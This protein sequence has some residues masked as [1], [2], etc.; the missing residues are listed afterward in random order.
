MSKLAYIPEATVGRAAGVPYV[1][2]PPSDRVRA[3]APAVVGWHLGDPP[4]TETALAAALPLREL[5]AWRIYL[6]LPL[7]GSRL[8]AG[9]WDE[10]MQAASEDAVLKLQKPVAYGAAE[11]FGPAFAELQ[12]RLGFDTARIGLMGGS[13]G[14]A[15]AQL[16]IAEGDLQIS[17]AVLV[18]PLVQLRR[19]VDAMRRRFGLTYTWTAESKAVAARLDFVARASEIADRTRTAVLLVIGEHDDAGFRAP[20]AEL[21]EALKRSY[22]DEAR[23]ELVTIPGMAHALAEEPGSDPAPQTAHAAVV[24]RHA[25]QWFRR[26]LVER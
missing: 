11:E 12:G 20:A 10:L 23:A 9:G 4:R 15:V 2:M 24:D 14:A 16:V 6:G 18:N 1:A 22:A 25:V 5:N 13:I 8:P 21:A 3:S 26:Y 17:A 7:S 19:A